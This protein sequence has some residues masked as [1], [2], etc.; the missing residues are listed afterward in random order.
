MTY[1]TVCRSCD[2]LDEDCEDGGEAHD[3]AVDHVEA[4]PDHT[5]GYR[6]VA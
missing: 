1:R 3:V 6:R 5:A 2:E 4:H